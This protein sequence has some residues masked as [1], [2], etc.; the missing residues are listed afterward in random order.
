MTMTLVFT[1]FTAVAAWALFRSA[2][3]IEPRPHPWIELVLSL[4]ACAA[5][6]LRLVWVAATVSFLSAPA[7][8]PAG[9]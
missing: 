8:P 1:A 4:V 5:S 9:G 3:R 7:S 2:R 6:G